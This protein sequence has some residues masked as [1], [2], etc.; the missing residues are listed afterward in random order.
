MSDWI[1]DELKLLSFD[2]K[3]LTLAVIITITAITT[4]FAS[5]A[6]IEAIFLPIVDRIVTNMAHWKI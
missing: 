1:G 5:N 3:E 4:E 6:S 2:R